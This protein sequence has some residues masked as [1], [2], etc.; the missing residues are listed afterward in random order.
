[1]KVIIVGHH[2][3]SPWIWKLADALG[4]NF[5]CA[6]VDYSN[7]GSLEGHQ[8]A[9]RC[10][11][12]HADMGERVVIMEDDA[13]PVQG[14]V[15]LAERIIADHPDDAISFYLGTSR[16]Y[17]WQPIIDR[18]IASSVDGM[19]RLPELIHGVCYSIPNHLLD[20]VL[21]GLQGLGK[22]AADEAVSGALGEPVWYPVES[23]VEHRDQG[24]VEQHPDG[25]PRTERRVARAL[26]APLAY[27]R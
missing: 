22:Q 26:A 17:H 15:S 18:K 6:V 7:R 16:P 25:E 4:P 24:T 9:L 11:K 5:A 12:I 8:K 23:L 2:E 20:R 27:E 14:F 13:I 3:R 10:A 21:R 19:I 1:M